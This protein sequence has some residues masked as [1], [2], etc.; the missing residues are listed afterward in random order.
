MIRK[1]RILCGGAG[2]VRAARMSPRRQITCS[3]RGRR[4]A[5][6]SAVACA[7]LLAVSF[8][9]GSRDAIWMA[10]VPF[11]FLARSASN[12]SRSPDRAPA[13][14]GCGPSSSTSRPADRGEDRPFVVGGAVLPR[15]VSRVAG[16]RSATGCCS[17]RGCGRR[18]PGP[19]LSRP[20]APRIPPTRR[21]IRMPE[22]PLLDCARP[23]SWDTPKPTNPSGR[24]CALWLELELPKLAPQPRA[25]RW[26]RAPE[27]GHRLA[28]ALVRG[29]GYAGLHWRGR[30]SVAG[31][32]SPT[33]SS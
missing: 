2:M 1:G 24:R 28:A 22:R 19:R 25:T 23:C 7:A 17:S 8:A 6:L 33:P 29:R 21:R 16:R 26:V 32:A 5:K 13:G 20:P 18:R 31:G 4:P 3:A 12:G 11:L 9:T 10:A 30:V 14:R 15:P 27:V